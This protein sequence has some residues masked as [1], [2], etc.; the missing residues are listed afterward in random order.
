MGRLSTGMALRMGSN[1]S[2][3]SGEGRAYGATL[4]PE[5]AHRIVA[6][7]VARSTEGLGRAGKVVGGTPPGDRTST[8]EWERCTLRGACMYGKVVGWNRAEAADKSGVAVPR[9][10]AIELVRESGTIRGR[11]SGPARPWEDRP[12][13]GLLERIGDSAPATVD[14]EERAEFATKGDPTI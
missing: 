1:S 12:V 3:A 11:R 8:S 4:T 9:R 2:A 5:P 6:A 7:V 14:V 13:P 10:D